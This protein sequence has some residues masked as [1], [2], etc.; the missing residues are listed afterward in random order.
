[1]EKKFVV[2]LPVS[3]FF[4]TSSVV[5][6]SYLPIFSL[7]PYILLTPSLFI[8]KVWL[9]RVRRGRWVPSFPSES[10]TRIPGES[11]SLCSREK[12]EKRLEV[13]SSTSL[14][15][16]WIT[17][18][19]RIRDN[20]YKGRHTAWEEPAKV[21][22]DERRRCNYILLSSHPSIPSSSSQAHSTTGW[23]L[24]QALSFIIIS[25]N[26]FPRGRRKLGNYWY[27]WSRAREPT[28]ILQ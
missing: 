22:S 2:P 1:M 6:S 21:G 9:I 15:V 14:G 16:Q 19:T 10:P 26:C 4:L 23:L 11:S 27:S 25:A 12:D 24:F 13:A 3:D 7:F 20:G 18:D 17:K 5:V 8:L 28:R